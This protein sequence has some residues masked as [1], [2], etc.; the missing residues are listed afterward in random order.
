MDTCKIRNRTFKSEAVVSQEV[1]LRVTN[2][3]AL[4]ADM[5][6]VASCSA[7]LKSEL[8]KEAGIHPDLEFAAFMS[9]FGS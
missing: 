2:T 8:P 6:R 7:Q 1:D 4:A 9:I 3:D 5:D